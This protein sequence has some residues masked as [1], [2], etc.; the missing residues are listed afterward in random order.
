MKMTKNKFK[1][2][3]P[4]K[5]NQFLIFKNESRTSGFGF[6][7]TFLNIS[8]FHCH[9]TFLQF[10]FNEFPSNTQHIC[11]FIKVGLRRRHYQPILT[12][13][14]VTAILTTISIFEKR[15]TARPSLSTMGM[16]EI[17]R[18]KNSLRAWMSGASVT[19]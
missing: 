3:L 17:L 16:A 4:K 18:S 19:S 8:K 12:K 13:K 14:D 11:A 6:R 15:S 5:Y 9:Q 10:N 1:N 2:R 7:L